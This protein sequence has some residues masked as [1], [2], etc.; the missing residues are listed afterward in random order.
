LRDHVFI[1]DLDGTLLD[2]SAM[3]P[4]PGKL[5]L[6]RLI[7]SGVAFTVASARSVASMRR[8]LRGLRV[9]LPVIAFNGAFISDLHSGRHIIVNALDPGLATGVF[10]LL[11][12][13]GAAPLVSTFDGAE[14]HVFFDKPRNDGVAAY[15]AARSAAA[16]PRMRRVPDVREGLAEQVICQTVIGRHEELADLAPQLAQQ[17]GDRI[18]THLF[19]DTYNPGWFWLTVHDRRATKDQAVAALLAHCGLKGRPVT[20]FGDHL[21][22]IALLRAA[23]R[24]VAVTGAIEAVRVMAHEVIGA[25]ED[26]AVPRYIAGVTGF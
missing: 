22:D 6:E 21:N 7:D 1:S 5:I 26:H 14:D 11:T 16:D 2:R 3:L 15:L 13:A 25:A 8:A 17:F 10:E 12:T 18:S 20:A 9:A 19:D 24:A 4:E 23:T